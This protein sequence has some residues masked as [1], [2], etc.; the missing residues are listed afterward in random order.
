MVNEPPEQYRKTSAD[1]KT[2]DRLDNLQ[3]LEKYKSK[4]FKL[5]VLRIMIEFLYN[6]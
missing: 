5:A 6:K 2:I 1:K 3:S 4:Y